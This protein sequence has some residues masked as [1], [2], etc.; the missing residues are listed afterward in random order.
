MKMLEETQTMNLSSLGRI[1]IGSFLMQFHLF[2]DFSICGIL[3]MEPLQTPASDCIAFG[4]DVTNGTG[5]YVAQ[6]M[7]K[8]EQVIHRTSVPLGGVVFL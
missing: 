7:K 5:S 8:T 2:V 1:L 6:L 3:R 4:V